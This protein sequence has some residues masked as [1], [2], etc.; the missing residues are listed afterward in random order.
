MKKIILTSLVFAMG[1][2]AA[3]AQTKKKSKKAKPLTAEQKQK[4]TLAKMESDRQAKFETQ[5]LERLEADSIRKAEEQMEEF[6]KD[7]LRQ[8]WKAKRLAVADSTNQATWA[9]TAMDR[10][11]RFDHDRSQNAILKSAGVNDV[12]G[13]KVKAINEQY[14]DRAKSVK[15]DSTLT[16]E[17]I[18]AQLASIN[19]ERR[20]KIKEVIGT[21][22]EKK[23]EKSRKSYSMKN[24]DD[25]DAKWINDAAMVK[26]NK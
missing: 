17:Q 13:R 11:A 9:K 2:F 26:K 10:D 20:A 3:E 15:M 14:N 23:L 12:Q 16:Q 24:N 22:K 5:R 8:D 19:D 1:F 4:S 21:S 25:H 6:T 18:S 7:S